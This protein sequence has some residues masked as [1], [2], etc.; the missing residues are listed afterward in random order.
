[1]INHKLTLNFKLTLGL[2]ALSGSAFAMEQENISNKDSEENKE[3]KVDF[4]KIFPQEIIQEI[5]RF[6]IDGIKYPKIKNASQSDD[7]KNIKTV[8]K[9]LNLIVKNFAQYK[10]IEFK[11]YDEINKPLFDELSKPSFEIDFKLVLELIKNGADLNLQNNAGLTALMMAAYINKTEIAKALIAA[12]ADLNLQDKFGK[13]ALMRAARWGHTEIVKAL[14]D[15]H[16]DLNLQDNNGDTALDIAQL[17]D[18]PAAIV[19]LLKSKG[20]KTGKELKLLAL[21]NENEKNK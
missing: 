18:L 8:C 4:T 21:A 11:K 5:L 9:E 16:A 10:K 2:L 7:F 6:C 14:I 17:I 12:G 1:M 3:I 20:A 19:E 13:T 15:A